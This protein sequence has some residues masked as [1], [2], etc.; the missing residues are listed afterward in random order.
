MTWHFYAILTFGFGL[1]LGWRNRKRRD[2]SAVN[3]AD[4]APLWLDGLPVGAVD[5]AGNLLWLTAAAENLLGRVSAEVSGRPLA[6]LLVPGTEESQDTLILRNHDD[7][8]VDGVAGPLRL[9]F[10]GEDESIYPVE[11]TVAKTPDAAGARLIFINGRSEMTELEQDLERQKQATEQANEEL[12]QVTSHLESTA[13][14]A[15][16]MAIQAELA[17]GAKSDFLANMSHEIRT[18]LNAVIG[19]T[20]LL[21][22]STLQAEQKEYVSVIQSSSEGLLNLINDILDISKIEAGKMELE[23]IEFELADV[24]ESAVEIFGVRAQGKGLELLC[25][26]EPSIPRQ[27][28]GDPTRLRQVLVNLL[29]NAMKFTESGQVDLSVVRTD[30]EAAGDNAL[31][32][33]FKVHDTGIGI[34]QENLDKVF[35][36]FSQAESSTTRKF[37]GTGLGLNISKLIVGMMNGEFWVE[38]TEGE[39]STFQFTA[40]LGLS[41]EQTTVLQPKEKTRTAFLYFAN[42]SGREFIGQTLAFH[43]FEVTACASP[44]HGLA[45][46]RGMQPPPSVVVADLDVRDE[47]ALGFLRDLREDA[48]LKDAAVILAAPMGTANVELQNQL[49]L[50]GFVSKPVRQTALLNLVACATGARVEKKE[51]CPPASQAQKKADVSNRILLVEDNKDNQ[52]LATKILQGAGFGV[53]L[54]ENGL[55][56][57][58]ATSAFAYDLILMDIYMPEMDGFEATTAIREY[59]AEHGLERVPI[60]AFTAH[61]IEGYRERCLEGGMDDFITKPIRKKHLLETVNTWLDPRPA[62]LVVDDTADNL[63]LMKNYFRKQPDYRVFFASNGEEAVNSFKQRSISLI[64]MDMEMPVMDGYTATEKIRSLENGRDIPILAL[65]A[66]S[67]SKRLKKCFESGCD[68]ALTKPIRKKQ[69][70]DAVDRYVN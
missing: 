5:A 11:L 56:A 34:S 44:E 32:L 48:H 55:E 64:L 47:V 58:A 53:D 14:F 43:G 15:K 18:P 41:A 63:A 21:L 45:Q 67:D 2:A 28:V 39:G 50:A 10:T 33:H 38:S 19:M 20:E 1:I 65:T 17:N 26:L 3:F 42:D 13:L 57:V 37:G 69:L 49:G 60:I 70:F 4:C 46:I 7:L 51:D 68:E 35:N 36:K 25:F 27:V 22:E 24:V 30:E 62:V 52:L 66:H 31:K 40:E 23:N 16:E 29:G 61:A 9:Q 59:E 6:D 54:A 12:N 8:V